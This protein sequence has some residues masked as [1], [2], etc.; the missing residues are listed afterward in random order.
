SYQYIEMP[1]RDLA[2]KH[3]YRIKKTSNIDD[4]NIV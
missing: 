4:L 2:K 3:A 1:S